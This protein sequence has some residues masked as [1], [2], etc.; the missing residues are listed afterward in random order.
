LP[1]PIGEGELNALRGVERI[2]VQA[3]SRDDHQ[4]PAL[5]L[6]GFPP[7][8][9]M[10]PIGTHLAMMPTVVLDDDLEFGVAEIES[11]CPVAVRFTKDVVDSWLGQP[12]QHDEHPQSRFPWRIDTCPYV[13]CGSAS[14]SGS[15][16]YIT[17][18]RF[19]QFVRRGPLTSY[20][21]I[22]KRDQVHKVFAGGG[23]LQEDAS[24]VRN[25]QSSVTAGIL[26]ASGAMGND[27]PPLRSRRSL[28]NADVDLIELADE[29]APEGQRRSRDSRTSRAD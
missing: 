25:E 12:T 8:D 7:F 11:L 23:Y 26:V 18:S 1:A 27:A 3:F 5:A 4:A 28:R 6:E 15:L 24:G 19:D 16:A 14:E 13:R 17:V 9:V 29:G 21:R 10:E 2:V 22:A 20:E